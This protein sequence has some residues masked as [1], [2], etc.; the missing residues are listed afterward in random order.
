MGAGSPFIRPFKLTV[1]LHV[2]G[3]EALL[4][5]PDEALGLL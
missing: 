5:V 4:C 2:K 3:G 1:Y